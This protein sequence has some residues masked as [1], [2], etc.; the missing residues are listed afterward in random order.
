MERSQERRERLHRLIDLARASRGWSRARLARA[1]HRDPTKLYPE[2]GNPKLDFLMNLADVLEWSVG[3]VADAVWGKGMAELIAAEPK[4]R[5]F[6]QVDDEALAAYDHGQHERM[7]ELARE[8]YAIA[9]DADGRALACIREA[10]AWD[11]L[12]RYP[13]ALDAIQRGLNETGISVRYR[14]I[15]QA[16]LANAQYTLWQL[17]PALGTAQVLADWYASNPA[18]ETESEKRLAFVQYVRGNIRRRLMAIEPESAPQHCGAGMA[19]LTAAQATY[20]RLA[21]ELDD[22]TLGGIANTCRGGLLELRVENGD[23]AASEAVDTIIS[24]LDAV[25]N[26]EE[27]GSG[28]WLESYGWWSIFGSN[29]A[30]RHLEGRRLQQSLAILTNKALE[31]ADRLDNWALRERVFTMQ[32]ALHQRMVDST[33]FDLPFT[34]D[35]ED[36]TLIAGAMGRFPSFR[37]IGWQIL[38]TA[39]VVES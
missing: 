6:I 23:L 9:R 37:S 17:T 12:G 31:I 29:I 36:R 20:E 39:R 13:K 18:D 4:D 34:I 2:S 32:Y 21:A 5:T 7:A 25:V 11:G 1:L 22:Q 27:M 24:G 14:L 15:L 26:I 33:G 3:D 8:M 30:L 35:D 28:D 16:N 10:G 38:E 19:D